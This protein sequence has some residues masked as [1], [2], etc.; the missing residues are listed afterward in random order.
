MF[1]ILA[2]SRRQNLCFRRTFDIRHYQPAIGA[3]PLLVAARR[4][5][6]A[7]RYGGKNGAQL[8]ATCHLGPA[9]DRPGRQLERNLT[10][11]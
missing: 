10:G 5:W 1:R 7:I 6:R 4:S 9:C 2:S 3:D 11:Y 8:G